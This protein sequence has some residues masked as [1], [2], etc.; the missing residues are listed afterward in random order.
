[1]KVLFLKLGLMATFEAETGVVPSLRAAW[2]TEEV[3][4]IGWGNSLA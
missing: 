2:A 3:Q 4:V 1:M